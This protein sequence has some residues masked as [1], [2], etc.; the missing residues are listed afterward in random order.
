MQSFK[1]M[2]ETRDLSEA[3]TLNGVLSELVE[4]TPAAIS[5]FESP[6]GWRIDAYYAEAPD[7]QLMQGQVAALLPSPPQLNVEAVP[8]EN[9]VA[10]SQAALPPVSAGRFT[11]HGS[12]DRCKVI[13]GPNTLEIEAGE[14]FGT[15]HHATTQGCLL[16]IDQLCRGRWFRR[17]LDVGCGSGVLAIASARAL[18]RAAIEAIDNDPL[19]VAVAR[20]N[21]RSNGVGRRIRFKVANGVANRGER[22]P[23]YDLVLANILA[24]PL[25]EMA[26]AIAAATEPGGIIVLSGLLTPQAAQVTA[27]YRACEAVLVDHRRLAGWSTLMLVRRRSRARS[28]SRRPRPSA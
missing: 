16:A 17:V 8:D 5:M 9:W 21:A 22:G 10:I 25:M 1:I 23:P 28:L 24:E 18:P 27:A 20:A 3:R 19:A 4:P 2:V 13:R 11:I 26:P 12:H 7:M 14:A 6:V 15:A